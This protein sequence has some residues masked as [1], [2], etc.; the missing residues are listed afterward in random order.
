MYIML[1][2]IPIWPHRDEII[3]NMPA[4]FK[5][6]FPRSGTLVILECTELKTHE[7]L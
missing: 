2:G 4:Q 1:G 7:F 3:S 5:S 6:E